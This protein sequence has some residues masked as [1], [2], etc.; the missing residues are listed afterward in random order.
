[1]EELPSVEVSTEEVAPIEESTY[2]MDPMEEP[3]EEP[4]VKKAPTSEPAGQLDIPLV[5]HEDK[6]KGEV[7]HSDYS[8]WM[9]VLHPA[10][11][12]T[13]TKEIPPPPSDLR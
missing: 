8:G 4:T 11:L 7:S 12:A 1:M 3:T 2:E 9:E 13:S 5:W 6:G 10:W